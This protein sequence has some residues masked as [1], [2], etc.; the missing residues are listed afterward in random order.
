VHCPA[1]LTVVA[2][3]KTY[4]KHVPFHPGSPEA[5]L[6]REDVI[7]KFERNTRWYF[8]D[9]ARAIAEE[10]GAE[11]E[12]EPVARFVRRATRQGALRTA[13]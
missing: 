5:A 1:R 8:G 6:S 13:S 7:A 10:M 11:A 4:Y 3:G 12:K 9:E 2:K